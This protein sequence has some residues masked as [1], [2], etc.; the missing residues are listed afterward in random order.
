VE[1]A[2]QEE[3]VQEQLLPVQQGWLRV[4]PACSAKPAAVMRSREAVQVRQQ[5]AE[6]Q[7]LQEEALQGLLRMRRALQPAPAAPATGVRGQ[8]QVQEQEDEESIVQ[9]GHLRRL[10]RMRWSLL[11]CTSPATCAVRSRQDLQV[12]DQEVHH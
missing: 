1:E 12:Q 5:K 3:G 7:V 9:E 8:L 2:V 10:L 6:G 11:R 4:P